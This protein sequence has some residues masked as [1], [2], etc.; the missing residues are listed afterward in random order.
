MKY[1]DAIK[2][3]RCPRW[4]KD[5]NVEHAD[6]EFTELDRVIWNNGRWEGG[7]WRNGIWKDGRWEGG[8]WEGGLWE[9]GI[10][11]GGRWEG[12]TWR[13]GIW[14]NGIWRNG[15]WEGGR[16]EGGLWEGGFRIPMS[17]WFV[18]VSNDKLVKIGCKV[19]TIPEWDEWFAGSEE[20]D[21][22]RDSE[23]FKLIRANY[24][25]VKAFHLNMNK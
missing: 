8:R 10:W 23:E 3:P 4:L 17:K 13:N 6:I 7:T 16:W 24:E 25:A 19:K 21:T 1:E 14:R 20:F 11:V 22:P 9:G 15:R 5:A 18:T 12:G 2:D